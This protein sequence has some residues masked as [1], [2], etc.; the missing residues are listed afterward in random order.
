MST[1]HAMSESSVEHHADSM[2]IDGQHHNDPPNGDKVLPVHLQHVTD[3]MVRP[4]YA[5]RND[6][7]EQEIATVRDLQP[8]RVYESVKLLQHK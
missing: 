8:A 2:P 1:D 4:D 3:T 5:P 6:R 7:E